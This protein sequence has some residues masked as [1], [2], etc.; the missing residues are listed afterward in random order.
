MRAQE[1]L[2]KSPKFS[3]NEF[4]VQE[5]AMKDLDNAQAF[6]DA[7]LSSVPSS[8]RAL[9]MLGPKHLPLV[10]RNPLNLEEF[11]SACLLDCSPK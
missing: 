4:I 9:G 6:K 11:W 10:D 7:L 2:K 3:M 5:P 8:G 1:L